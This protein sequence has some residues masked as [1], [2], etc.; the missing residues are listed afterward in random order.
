MLPKAG[1]YAK[2][3]DRETKQMNFLIEDDHDTWNEVSK[4]TKPK[5]RKQNKSLQG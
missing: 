5:F 2:I 4:P 1:T 3:Y